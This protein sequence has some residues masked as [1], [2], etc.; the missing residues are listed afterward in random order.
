MDDYKILEFTKTFL[1]NEEYEKDCD[2]QILKNEKNKE[3]IVYYILII[4]NK[5]FQIKI[6]KDDENK[7]SKLFIEKIYA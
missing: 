7:D 3:R 4:I 2:I 1:I 5:N 6:I